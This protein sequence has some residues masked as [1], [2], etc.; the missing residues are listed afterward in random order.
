[1][2]TS[3]ISFVPYFNLKVLSRAE[4]MQLIADKSGFKKGDIDEVLNAFREILLE[5]VLQKGNEIRIREFGTFKRKE[6]SARTGR[7]PRTGES[8]DIAASSSVSF[9]CSSSL[10]SKSDE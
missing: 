2:T 6:L 8:M 5:E 9:S 3:K 1:M 10:K 4:F 7:N